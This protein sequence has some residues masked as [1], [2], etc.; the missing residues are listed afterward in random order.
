MTMQENRHRFE[1]LFTIV[2]FTRAYKC[3]YETR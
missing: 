1:L 2:Q 3:S